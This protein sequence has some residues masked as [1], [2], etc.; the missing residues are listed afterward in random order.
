[1]FSLKGQS[2][3]HR[4]FIYLACYYANNFKGLLPLSCLSP[5]HPSNPLPLKNF[6]RLKSSQKNIYNNFFFIV[7]GLL[8]PHAERFGVSRMQDFCCFCLFLQLYKQCYPHPHSAVVPP[9]SHL[10]V[11]S[12]LANKGQILFQFALSQAVG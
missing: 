3:S 7:L 6:V 10:A 9:P 4:V 5:S 1:M 11:S 12:H 8:S 2:S